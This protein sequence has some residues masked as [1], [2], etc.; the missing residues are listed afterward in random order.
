LSL[1]SARPQHEYVWVTAT[2]QAFQEIL[3]RLSGESLDAVTDLLQVVAGERAPMQ[4][5]AQWSLMRREIPTP[6]EIE[7]AAFRTTNSFSPVKERF[8]GHLESDEPLEVLIRGHLWVEASLSGLLSRRLVKPEAIDDA[9]FTFMHRL[10]LCD[11][12]GLVPSDL[13]PVIR[14]LNKLRNRVAHNLD[15]AV[16]ETDQRELI[17]LCSPRIIEASGMKLKV[18]T[19]PIGIAT[20]IS[21]AVIELHANMDW[22]DANKRQA[23]YMR[24]VVSQVL[25][26]EARGVTTD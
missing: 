26:P 8:R 14:R 7:L 16:S 25:G 23:E 22:L 3:P 4:V 18:K 21:V 19:F 15:A 17:A 5:D 24:D 2:T 12:L 20:I 1:R 9:R 11:A 13:L 6:F 10:A